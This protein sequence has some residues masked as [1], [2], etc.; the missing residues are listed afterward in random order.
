MRCP[1]ASRIKSEQLQK[2]DAPRLASEGIT[3]KSIQP[4]YTTNSS[5]PPVRRNARGTS[6]GAARHVAPFTREQREGIHT[7]I[8]TLPCG[9]GAA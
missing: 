7:F 4:N 6:H 3:D 2:K 1:Q 9:G 5:P 8:A